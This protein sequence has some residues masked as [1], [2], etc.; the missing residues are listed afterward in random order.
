MLHNPSRLVLCEDPLQCLCLLLKSP[1][2]TTVQVSELC[3]NES[4]LSQGNI[5][6]SEGKTCIVFFM[7][8]LWGG[9]KL[10]SMID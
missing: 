8:V 3:V 9:V 1:G 5:K 2:N 4:Y 6:S 10:P 7:F